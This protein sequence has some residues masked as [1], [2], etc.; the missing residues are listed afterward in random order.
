MDKAYWFFVD[1]EMKDFVQD[2][3]IFACLRDIHWDFEDTWEWYEYGSLND[4]L[5]I[6]IS[7]EHDWIKGNYE[8]PVLLRYT[9][10]GTDIQQ[11]GAS[12]SHQLGVTVFYGEVAY[13]NGNDM[14]LLEEHVWDHEC[15]KKFR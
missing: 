1:R 9:R 11:I 3:D 2:V 4:A 14:A 12:I 6:N 15:H 13:K 5:Y 8:S 7:R 10:L